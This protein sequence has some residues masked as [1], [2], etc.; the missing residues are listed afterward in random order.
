MQYH[1]PAGVT[2]AEV[3]DRHSQTRSGSPFH[4]VNAAV[5]IDF[6]ARDRAAIPAIPATAAW[7]RWLTGPDMQIQGCVACDCLPTHTMTL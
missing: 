1:T 2:V 6:Y 4:P 5:K 7:V 3:R